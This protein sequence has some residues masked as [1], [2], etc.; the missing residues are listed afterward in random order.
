MK[1]YKTKFSIV[2]IAFCIFANARAD[3][4]N[5]T[6][7]APGQEAKISVVTVPTAEDA[8][9]QLHKD[10]ESISALQTFVINDSDGQITNE[11]I[12]AALNNPHLV[13]IA[14]GN[15]AAIFAAVQTQAE[16]AH[17]QPLIASQVQ[18]RLQT[19]L[20]EAKNLNRAISIAKGILV[21]NAQYFFIYKKFFEGQVL[22]AFMMALLHGT[23][24][25]AYQLNIFGFNNDLH[26]VANKFFNSYEPLKKFAIPTGGP[27]EKYFPRS[28]IIA[29]K[30]GVS[31][32]GIIFCSMYV[33]IVFSGLYGFGIHYAPDMLLQT[34]NEQGHSFNSLTAGAIALGFI[35]HVWHSALG[36]AYG[37]LGPVNALRGAI[38]PHT[39]LNK[40]DQKIALMWSG[41]VF[42]AAASLFIIMAQ[43]PGVVLLRNIVI[44]ATAG[45]IAWDFRKI[46]TPTFVS[47]VYAGLRLIASKWLEKFPVLNAQ[48]QH[49]FDRISLGLKNRANQSDAN[50]T[51]AA[52]N[53]EFRPEIVAETE[54]APVTTKAQPKL[55]VGCRIILIQP[56]SGILVK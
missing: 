15:T 37:D 30:A 55:N 53:D 12:R 25:T 51:E 33:G 10:S 41:A 38:L 27:V 52:S 6:L 8:L 43:M 28:H 1:R 32:A 31:A 14:T 42:G 4:I 39:G 18:A 26:L 35:T 49:I 16:F 45:G 20:N 40:H 17:S 36:E 54:R 21:G 56:L 24:S 22:P 7:E 2:I 46:F 9:A 13:D 50:S 5:F 34:V 3:E 11:Q 29:K 44:F 19:K 48:I 47:E 23:L